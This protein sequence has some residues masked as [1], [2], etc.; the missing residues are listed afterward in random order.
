M[1]DTSRRITALLQ[2]RILILDGAMGSLLQE[3]APA[4]SFSPD[5]FCLEKPEL[6]SAIHREYLEAGADII[7]T[8]SFNANALSLADYG[9]AEKA[10]E[11]CR[12]SAVLAREAADRFTAADKP[13]FVAGSM[14]PTSK[15]AA[16]APDVEDPS[17][18][19]ISWDELEAIYHES[20]AGLVEGG[21]DLL[22]LETI[23]DT[24]NAKA[25][26]AAVRRL[27]E[28]TGRDIPLM[29]SATISDASGRLLA[30]QTLEAFV[31]S[32]LHARP[33]SLGLNCSLGA[34]KLLPHLK[35]LAA[36]SPAAVSCHPNAGL[37]NSSGG[38]D[39]KPDETAALIQVF[40]D[41]GLVNIVGGCCGTTP[42]HIAK[43]AERARSYPPRPF[44]ENGFGGAAGGMLAGLEA[45]DLGKGFVDIGERCNVAGS[46]KFLRFVRE[47]SWDQALDIA[48]DMIDAGA[49]IIDICMDDALL[50]GTAAMTRFLALALSDPH[51][52]RV[53]VMIDSS[54]WEILEA[55]LK[56]VQGK[57]LV[58][59]I[60]LKEGE[61]EFLRRAKL[62]HQYGAAAVVMLFDEQGQAQNYGRKIEIA[63]RSFRLLT[64]S[65]FPPEDIVFDPNVL[66]IAT[67]M[68]EHDPYAL[69][70]IRAVAWIREHCPR[71]HVSAGVSNLS[72]SFRG[73]ETVRRA[74]HAVFLEHAVKAGLGM[75]IVNPSGLVSA[76]ELPAELREAA[77]DA[78]LCRGDNPSEKIIG[79]ALR[80]KENEAGAA[81]S[82]VPSW[83]TLP[84]EERLSHALV[85]G[86]DS[87]IEEDVLALKRD[88][89]ALALVEGPLMRGMETVGKLF[90]EGRLFLPQVIRS[91]RVMKKAVAVLE[92]F[93]ESEKEA[94]PDADSR[95]DAR[96][97]IVLATV[98][99]DVHDIGKNITGLVLSC[100]GFEVIDLGVMVPAEKIL[101]TARERGADFVGLS[102]L[103]SPSL[104]EMVKLAQAMEA[105]GF[106]IPL[107]IGGAAASTAHTALRIA[108]AYSGPVVYVSDAG[109]SPAVLRS[110]LSAAARETFLTAL[111]AAYEKALAVH[112]EIEDRRSFL[113]LEEAR[114][115]R[116][117]VD[118]AAANIAAR[119]STVI[120]YDDY[121]LDQVAPLL[122]WNE[123]CAAW[124]LKKPDAASEREKLIDDAS[125]M[126]AKIVSGKL[127]TL[128]A[129]TGFFPA[130]SENEDVIVLDGRGD[131]NGAAVLPERARFC[132]LRNQQSRP[133][134]D[135]R[136]KNTA[137]SAAYNLCL[138]DFILPR[139]LSGAAGAPRNDWLGLF[140]VSAGFGLD[141]AAAPYRK[142]GDDYGALLAAS[143]S[144]HLAEAFAEKLHREMSGGSGIRPAFGYA[145]CPDHED[146]RLC[147]SLLEAERRIGLTLTDSAMIRPAASICGMYFTHP[148]ARYFAAGKIDA[149]QLADW[150]RRKGITLDEARRR[151]GSL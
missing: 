12:V 88:M 143:L 21:A 95:A 139:S 10:R 61:A 94:G 17:K 5:L 134:A 128:K 79:L 16:I 132:F 69:E 97:K 1:P 34:Q 59:S 100:N 106:E 119:E 120:Q 131:Q 137:K 150:A 76:A 55:A 51:I 44:A 82:S 26:I 140:A 6:V 125:A 56:C 136:H 114:A 77:E 38:Y 84:P 25:A 107:L 4:F 22:M 83:R 53:P 141:A 13:R 133:A 23:F 74:L 3:R 105:R 64:A 85:Q 113:S 19:G 73:N 91:A 126:L 42:E 46:K 65:G 29:I 8:C 135:Q 30:G 37:P 33:L 146:K 67:G 117:P 7:T 68:A 98:K 142:A 58:N 90:G 92:P 41:Q 48:R 32:V 40:L 36:F 47:G 45:L 151:T 80:E 138:A 81:R 148:D 87:F 2:E 43:I 112:R 62:I 66:T 129:V 103:I 60:S 9:L 93:L 72:F 15:S 24:L 49:G 31:V 99:G 101:D 71:A 111:A 102:G 54:R 145:A 63:E 89:P 147:F 122:D 27:T 20:A 70:F 11:L 123:F 75:A 57:A 118:W 144:D 104:E 108:P 130:L 149:G 115:N 109:K 127:L 124:E 35:E 116:P 39:E 121:P 86:I 52:A 18:R 78:V 14:G 96:A 28:E 110:L 50:D